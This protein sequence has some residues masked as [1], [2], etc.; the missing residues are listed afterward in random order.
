MQYGFADMNIYEEITPEFLSK[1]SS[2]LLKAK[3]LVIDLNLPKNLLSTSSFAEKTILL[4][5]VPVSSPKMIHM[6][7]SLHSIDWLIINRD[8]TETF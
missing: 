8:E 5:I 4:V 7:N 1:Q 2:I 3:C 6:P